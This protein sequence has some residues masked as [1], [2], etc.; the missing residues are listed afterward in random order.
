[1]SIL[2]SRT[3]TALC[4]AAALSLSATPAMARGW[5]RYHGDGIDAGDVFAG[6][7]IVGGI[8]AIAAA[9]SKSGKDRAVRQDDGY[10]DRPN[11]NYRAPDY[12]DDAP[13]RYQDDRGDDGYSEGASS[14]W[15][16]GVSADGAVDAC[17]GEVEHG[18]RS[19][20]SI[21]SVNREADGWNVAGRIRG[22]N[23]FTCAVDGDGRVRGVSG[24]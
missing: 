17:V 18:S 22:G 8:A 24:F 20:G 1:M 14:N 5:H 10:P 13:Q 23:D 3:A 21:Q 12:Q 6:L 19:V 16:S 4:A 11:G 15:R 7:L 2:R 9:A